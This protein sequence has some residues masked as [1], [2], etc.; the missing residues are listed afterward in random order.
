MDHHFKKVSPQ[1]LVTPGADLEQN[2]SGGILV[3]MGTKIL[4]QGHLSDTE[5]RTSW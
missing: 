5:Q 4:E 3:R 2:E 1:C